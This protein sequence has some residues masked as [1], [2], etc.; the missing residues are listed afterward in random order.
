MGTYIIYTTEGFTTGPNPEVEIENCQVLGIIDAKSPESA[1][2]ELFKQNEWIAQAGF[3]ADHVV[4]RQLLTQ[5]VKKDLRTVIEYL[6][7]DELKSYQEDRYPGDHIFI[8]LR[9]LKKRL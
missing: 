8:N 6:W 3:S 4:V 5:T 7:Y 9:R 1:V 2:K